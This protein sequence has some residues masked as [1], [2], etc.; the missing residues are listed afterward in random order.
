KSLFLARDRL[1]KK[2]LVYSVCNQ[3]LYFASEIKAL[4]EAEEISREI[5]PVAIDLYLT[6]QAIPSPWTIF[7]KIKKLPPGHFL[8][9]KNGRVH[10][11]KYWQIDFTKKLKLKD[12][13][14]YMEAMWE[15]LKESTRIRMVSDVPL[16]A[17][18]SGGI[19]SSAI[20]GIMS[21][22]SDQP[23]KT[24]SVGFEESDFS[25]LQY[26]RIVAQR[27]NTSH[28]EFIITPDIISIL[29]KLVWH[30]NE[31]FGDSSMIPTFY[32]AKETKKYVT[33]AL[34]GDGG[35][36]NFAGYTRYWQTKLLEKIFLAYNKMPSFRTNIGNFFLKQYSRFPSKT[37][38]RIWKWLD[39]AEKNGF[40]YAYARRLIAFSPDIKKQFYSEDMKNTIQNFDPF[41]LVKDIWNAAGDIDLIEKMLATDF[42]LYL[43]EVLMVKMDIACM[44][45][46]LEARSPFLDQEFVELIASFPSHL[47][48]RKTV[49]K[50][51]L[52]RKLKNF[53]PEK[54][55][56]RKKMGFGIPVGRWFKTRLNQFI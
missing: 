38:F 48:F 18:L 4:I 42:Q 22:F 16:G 45:N 30:Y 39:D 15:K 43:P 51:I 33:V 34:N 7:K 24:F 40:D 1:G 21:E 49:S 26:A 53:L 10:I 29:P 31:P 41:S 11:E 12:D 52:K 56:S 8:M 54:I 46:S 44:A 50:Y 32:V 14:A 19:D 25:E 5:D 17:F 9:W 28:H 55:V 36:E 3:D 35:D 23:V 13:T 37:F 27:F 47:K 6:Y 2:P 20:V